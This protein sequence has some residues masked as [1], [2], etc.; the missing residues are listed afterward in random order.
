[1]LFFFHV[2]LVFRLE[3]E[4][5]HIKLKITFYKPPCSSLPSR[6]GKKEQKGAGVAQ[7]AKQRGTDVGVQVDGKGPRTL[8]YS[9]SNDAASDVDTPRTFLFF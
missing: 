4:R 9:T 7:E 5:E 3:V 2:I 6:R 8:C 1:M